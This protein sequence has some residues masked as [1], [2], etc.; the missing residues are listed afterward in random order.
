MI[1]YV[2]NI[3]SGSGNNPSFIE[4]LVPKLETLHPVVSAS[5]RKN[6]I[7]RLLHMIG[8][9]LRYRLKTKVVLIDTYSYQGFYFAW[10]IGLL[11][12]WLRI[13]YIPIIRG[14]DFINRI[15]NS[16]GMT[17]SFLRYAARVVAPSEY[18]YEG[19]KKKGIEVTFIPNFIEI[20][21]YT[22]K[23]SATLSPRLFWLRSFHAIYNPSLAIDV[24]EILKKKYPDIRL[25]MAGPDKDGSL[26]RCRALVKSKMLEQVVTFS[27]R[28]TKPQ[29]REIAP[30][31]SIF[32]NTTTIDNH[33]VSVIEA[34]ALGLVIVTTNVGG[35]PYLVRHNEDGLLV[36]S[37]DAAA[38][39]SSID[40]VL[41]D[42]AL[43]KRFQLNARA[44]V[45]LYDWL[46]VKEYWISLLNPFFVK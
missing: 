36:K 21:D 6:K 46:I 25:T 23:P 13:P 11:S 5:D 33:P 14:G 1:L 26:Q 45:E 8:V 19:L 35:V 38:F 7:F 17:T 20:G 24:V 15:E 42:T 31:H 10:I 9:L 39:A 2:G 28:L 12:R 43:A 18:M 4:L 44:K 16:P 27:G 34:M 22:F 37:G 40:S 29:I 30:D 41:K 3:L 32:I